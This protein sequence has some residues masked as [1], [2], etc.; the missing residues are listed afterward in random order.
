MSKRKIGDPE[1]VVR[2][3]DVVRVRE[4]FYDGEDVSAEEEFAD[5]V[6]STKTRDGP[7]LSCVFLDGLIK[8][9]VEKRKMKGGEIRAAIRRVASNVAFSMDVFQADVVVPAVATEAT[10]VDANTLRQEVHARLERFL[11]VFADK[12]KI[13][14]LPSTINYREIVRPFIE[15]CAKVTAVPL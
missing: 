8:H 7:D 11:Q 2:F 15:F 1:R 13:A 10:S 9:I 3:S 5:S 12:G 14:V 6:V 4:L